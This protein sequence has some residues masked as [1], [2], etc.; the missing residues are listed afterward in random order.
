[1]SRLF[2]V[3]RTSTLAERLTAFAQNG[4]GQNAAEVVAASAAVRPS[5]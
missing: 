1:M 2:V 4:G 3:H 5:R